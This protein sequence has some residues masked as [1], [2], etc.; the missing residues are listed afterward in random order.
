MKHTKKQRRAMADALEA[1]L[2]YLWDGVSDGVS[3]EYICDAV[4]LTRRSGAPDVQRE[5][6]RR[7][8]DA[9]TVRSWL[10]CHGHIQTSHRPQEVQAYRRRWMLALIEEFRS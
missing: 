5:I 4:W 1:A 9:V 2:P 8:D 7:L 10:N 6:T 3:E